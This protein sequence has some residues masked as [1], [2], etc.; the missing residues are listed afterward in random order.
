MTCT[1]LDLV[2]AEQ[3]LMACRSDPFPNC[4]L[5]VDLPADHAALAILSSL[6]DLPLV[7]LVDTA[8][9][10]VALLALAHGASDYLLKE[11]ITPARLAL[12]IH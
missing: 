6:A 1:S 12:T 2:S 9:E 3:A 8:H 4:V 11:A 5:L 7:V 10:D